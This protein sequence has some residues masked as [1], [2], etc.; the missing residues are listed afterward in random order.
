ME[1]V[2]NLIPT[3]LDKICLKEM[4]YS[5][6]QLLR[7]TKISNF[8]TLVNYGIKFDFKTKIVKLIHQ[9]IAFKSY[10]QNKISLIECEFNIVNYYSYSYKS[11]S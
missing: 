1:K 6:Y 4:S 10:Q 8:T 11:S 2:T 7:S 5:L 9:I 3:L